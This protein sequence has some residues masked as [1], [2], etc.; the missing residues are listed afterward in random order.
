M[1]TFGAPVPV[2]HDPVSWETDELAGG[3]KVVSDMDLVKVPVVPLAEGPIGMVC[4]LGTGGVTAVLV[5]AVESPCGLG[6]P[7]ATEP[8]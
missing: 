6:V 7:V 3:H 4:P 1:V 8:V 2:D 5:P